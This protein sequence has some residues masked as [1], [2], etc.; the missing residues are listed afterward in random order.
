MPHGIT[1]RSDILIPIA[2]GKGALKR[3]GGV[4][5]SSIETI[6]IRK[7]QRLRLMHEMS[8]D[9]ISKSS[10]SYFELFLFR[11]LSSIFST[12]LFFPY[13]PEDQGSGE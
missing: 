13:M 4:K 10:R 5:K 8:Y 12:P 9:I 6:A 3:S 7:E 11:N 1:K 2:V